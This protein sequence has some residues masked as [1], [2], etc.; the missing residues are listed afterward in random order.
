MGALPGLL[1]VPWIV[2][3]AG[4]RWSM[5]GA[6]AAPPGGPDTADV[7]SVPLV[8]PPFITRPCCAFG[9]DLDL[10]VAARSY[11]ATRRPT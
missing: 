8:P 5:G 6:R 1:G 10:T 4:P 3:C 2:A 7:R 9:M 11:T